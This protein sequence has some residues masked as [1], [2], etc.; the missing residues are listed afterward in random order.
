VLQQ[1]IFMGEDFSASFTANTDRFFMDRFDVSLEF[2]TLE[3][4]LVALLT[5]IMQRFV[6][7]SL[8]I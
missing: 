4:F 7:D 5:F 3:E 6:V 1:R 2:G 8:Q